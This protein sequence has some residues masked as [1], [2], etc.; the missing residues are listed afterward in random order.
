MVIVDLAAGTGTAISTVLFPVL[1]SFAGW[2]NNS[3]EDGVV[4]KFEW[5]QG[6]Q[7]VIRIGIG[8]V[9]AFYSLPTFGIN[10][11]LLSASA[12]ATLVDILWSAWKK[13]KLDTVVLAPKA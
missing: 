9:V 13:H 5:T 2:L 1:R 6:L 7:T 8:S 4:S 11:D 10:I 12:G 3:L